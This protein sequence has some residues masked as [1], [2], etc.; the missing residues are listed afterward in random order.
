MNTNKLHLLSE[1]DKAYIAGLLERC[2][3][4]I[5]THGRAN[6]HYTTSIVFAYP[7]S[8]IIT[9]LCDNVGG[10]EYK[11]KTGNKDHKTHKWIFKGKDCA[12][13]LTICYPYIK[14]KRNHANIMILFCA[15][16]RGRGQ[17]GLTQ[18]DINIR[19]DLSQKLKVLNQERGHA[20]GDIRLIK[21][22]ELYSFG[23]FDFLPDSDGFG[24]TIV[25]ISGFFD[26]FINHIQHKDT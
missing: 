15:Q 23:L 25:P 11:Y 3:F 21:D 24:E 18:Y 26:D 16:L 1:T 17:I 6:G 19:I 2:S 22:K 12:R 7:E 13:L 4:M 14:A 5:A 9:W 20:R 8:E 10:N